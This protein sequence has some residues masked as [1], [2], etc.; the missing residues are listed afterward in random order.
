MKNLN[1]VIEEI[2]ES[3]A[4]IQISAEGKHKPLDLAFFV[5]RKAL[6]STP[7]LATEPDL[8]RKRPNA[9]ILLPSISPPHIPPEVS[10]LDYPWFKMK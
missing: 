8:A 9:V 2:Y 10:E 6:R 3:F 5:T 1:Q 7:I 4:I